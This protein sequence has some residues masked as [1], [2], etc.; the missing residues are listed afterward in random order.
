VYWDVVMVAPYWLQVPVLCMQHVP[1]TQALHPA[2]DVL[3]IPVPLLVASLVVAHVRAAESGVLDIAAGTAGATAPLTVH[4]AVAG[5]ATLGHLAQ[6]EE[7]PQVLFAVQEA[8]AAVPDV[9][10]LPAQLVV[11]AVLASLLAAGRAGAEVP[12]AV[13]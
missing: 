3:P 13:V 2:T 5:D 12:A 7:I 6:A 8:A 10:L 1:Q 4:A 11:A 9:A